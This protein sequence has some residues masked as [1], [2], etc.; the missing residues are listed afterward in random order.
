[1]ENENIRENENLNLEETETENEVMPEEISAEP[2]EETEVIAGEVIEEM[3]AED[4]EISSD[5]DIIGD[6]WQ[7]EE[8]PVEVEL[9]EEELAAIREA[10]KKRTA[11]ILIISGIVALLV[12]LCAAFYCYSEGVGSK[13]AVNTPMQVSEHYLTGKGDNIKFQSPVTS[14]FK[15]MFGKEKDAVMTVNGKAVD[16][17]IFSYI[18]NVLGINSVSSLIQTGMLASIEDFKWDMP[19]YTTGLSYLEYAKGLGINSLIPVYS[20]AAA[21]EKHGIA[22][23]EEEE[24]KI[25]DGIEE[26]KAQYGENFELR[27]RRK[28]NNIR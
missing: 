27:K 26:L 9:T 21:G 18:T 24:Q 13:T 1:M 7:A 8:T 20:L 17:K 15:T 3:P 4:G 16:E 23:T 10:K 14:A 25:R 5:E 19:E 6:E 12:A 28:I 22:L 2:V 11:K